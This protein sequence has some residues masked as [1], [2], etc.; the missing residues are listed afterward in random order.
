MTLNSDLPPSTEMTLGK[1]SVVGNETRRGQR[2][3]AVYLGAEDEY[4]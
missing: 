1:V 3:R 2:E 4:R